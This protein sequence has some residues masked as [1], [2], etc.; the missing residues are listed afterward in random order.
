[1]SITIAPLLGIF[2]YVKIF[3][4]KIERKKKKSYRSGS[5]WWAVAV[6]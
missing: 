3:Q 1:M 2:L 6:G 4:N 5:I